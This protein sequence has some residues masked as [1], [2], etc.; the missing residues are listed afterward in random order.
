MNRTYQRFLS[1]FAVTTLAGTLVAGGI[2]ASST[3]PIRETP[4]VELQRIDPQPVQSFAPLVK[5]VAPSVVQVATLVKA[6]NTRMEGTESENPMFR[7]FYGENPDRQGRRQFRTPAQRGA[8]SAVIV[9]PD[10]YL[11]T[12]NH[13]VDGADDLKV[14]LQDGR[15][16]EAKVVGTDPQ[17]DVAVIKVDSKDLP[18]IELADS[19]ATEVGD[20]VLA[21][22]NPFN[23]GQTVTSGI[24]SAKGRA[25]MGLDYEDFLQTDAAINPGNS[26]GALVDSRG[27]LIGIN[28]AIISG[29]G[30]NQGIGF[31]IPVNLA[32]SVM[33][34]LIKNG[35]VTRS[36]IGVMIQDVTPALATQFKMKDSKGALVGE[37][38]SGGPAAKA[39]LESG[40]IIVEFAGK[41]V[42]DSRHLKFSVASAKPG[43]T[44][45]V[46]IVRDGHTKTLKL[47]LQEM[48]SKLNLSSAGSEAAKEEGT[49]N[50]V[51]VDDLNAQTRRQ[52]NIPAD[53]EG[54]LVTEV[55]PSSPAF[56]SNLRPGDVIMA[57]NRKSVAGAE[58]A[59]KLTE[60]AEDHTSLLRVWS[61]GGSRY[62]VVDESK[63]N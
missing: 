26:G 35:H 30:G 24:I 12:N 58:D 36:Y 49:L 5:R 44:V 45:P 10:G 53:V 34:G 6:K 9:S 1:A 33:D 50:G 41:P 39:G 55:D 19:D 47:K 28:T 60:K 16:F 54:A 3:S 15:E 14:R 27:R 43:S 17:T 32:R 25:T 8:G 29:S 38:K 56:E 23:L 2:A 22:G 20:V 57:I 62:I 13:V 61:K 52:F 37:V 48:D 18:A 31:A 40:D 63:A 46:M 7:W 11:L 42:E 4:K 59:V 51:T 21:V